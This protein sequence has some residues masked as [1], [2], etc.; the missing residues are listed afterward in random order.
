MDC[1]FKG[2]SL[3]E[4]NV[5]AFKCSSGTESMDPSTRHRWENLLIIVLG[6]TIDGQK[7]PLGFVESATENDRVPASDPSE[8]IRLRYKQMDRSLYT[9]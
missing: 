3:S 7:V 8:L 1:E 5:G 4:G 2:I 6:I 9:P